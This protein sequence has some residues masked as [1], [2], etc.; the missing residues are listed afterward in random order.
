MYFMNPALF[1]VHYQPLIYTLV[2][3]LKFELK[4]TDMLFCINSFLNLD[5]LSNEKVLEFKKP[6]AF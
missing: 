6:S 1:V 2:W 3:V 4:T 5:I